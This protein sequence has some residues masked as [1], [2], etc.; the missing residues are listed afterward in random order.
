MESIDHGRVKAGEDGVDSLRDGH[1]AVIE[2]QADVRRVSAQA[3]IEL[4]R[5]PLAVAGFGTAGFALGHDV[6]R[7]AEHDDRR[8]LPRRKH[9]RDLAQHWPEHDVLIDDREAGLRV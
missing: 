2:P 5:R 1:F 8:R 4:R 3:V 6:R 9:G 7:R